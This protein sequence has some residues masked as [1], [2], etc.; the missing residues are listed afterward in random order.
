MSEN[1]K[2]ATWS[3]QSS[4]VGPVFKQVPWV[5]FS[6][7]AIGET[8]AEL[9]DACTRLVGLLDK[10]ADIPFVG[11]QIQREILYRLLQS[12]EGDLPRDGGGIEV[13]SVF[14]FSVG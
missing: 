14:F 5:L 4:D 10:L 6:G 12:S 7:M 11:K 8:T 2:A 9:V 1:A 3:E 13:H